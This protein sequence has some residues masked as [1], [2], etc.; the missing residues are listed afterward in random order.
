MPVGIE[1]ATQTPK[2]IATVRA[3]SASSFGST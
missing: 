2:K 1:I 3:M